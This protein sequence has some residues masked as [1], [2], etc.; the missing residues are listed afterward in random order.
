MWTPATGLETFESLHCAE[1]ELN[2]R[3]HTPEQCSLLLE[4]LAADRPLALRSTSRPYHGMR[5]GFERIRNNFLSDRVHSVVDK[6]LGDIALASTTQLPAASLQHQLESCLL[7]HASVAPLEKALEAAQNTCFNAA[8]PAWL[9]SADAEAQLALATLLDQYRQHIDEPWTTITASHHW[10]LCLDK[11]PRSADPRLSLAAF[12]S[13][14]RAAI[15]TDPGCQERQTAGAE[16]LRAAA[17]RRKRQRRD[18][19][20]GTRVLPED[21]TV[22]HLNS[23]IKEADI[24]THYA[25]LLDSHLSHGERRVPERQ[26][27]FSPHLI[28]QSL[29]HAL[30]QYLRKS[31]S[32]QAHGFIKHVLGMPDG[33]ARTL[34]ADS[35]IVVRPLELLRR[36][37]KVA[38]TALG[39]YLIGRPDTQGPLVLYSPYDEHAAFREYTSES[40]FMNELGRPGPCGSWYSTGFPI[41]CAST[42]PN[43]YS[44]S[45]PSASPGTL[46]RVTSCTGCTTT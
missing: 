35:K 43:S 38:D 11:N 39:L 40:T 14:Y 8:L 17:S 36:A 12:E 33:V 32:A 37:Q 4:N 28:W 7:Q 26:A 24:G 25:A 27:L 23:L 1:S 21:L 29:E 18:H 2:R 9:A 5:I 41:P 30:C 20:L 22:T 6:A 42:T 45:R 16:R 34:F 31:L 46:S 19:P 13:G 44:V 10:A 3:L 15:G